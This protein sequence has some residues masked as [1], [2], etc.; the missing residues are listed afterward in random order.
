M[1]HTNTNS[2]KSSKLPLART[3]QP[4]TIEIL[5]DAAEAGE[6]FVAGDFNQSNPKSM[7]VRKDAQGVWRAHLQVPPGGHEYRLIV[8]NQWRDDPHA[9]GL[10]PNPFGSSNA[11]AQVA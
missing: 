1:K 11:F 9:A 10:I 4:R 7:P 5:F 8:D 2:P 3:S 6:V